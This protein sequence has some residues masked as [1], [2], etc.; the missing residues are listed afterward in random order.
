MDINRPAIVHDQEMTSSPT[1]NN[2]DDPKST[3]A[4]SEISEAMPGDEEESALAS[5]TKIQHMSEEQSLKPVPE[6]P[7]SSLT[8]MDND[9]NKMVMME[10]AGK[11]DVDNN[12]NDSN[13]G[14]VKPKKQDKKK[15]PEMNPRYKDVQETGQW[16]DLSSR[17]FYIAIAAFLLVIIVV[18][19]VVV[20]VVILPGNNDG[21]NVIIPAPT[22]APSMPATKIPPQ[23]ELALVLAAIE[24]SSFTAPLL[25]DGTLPNNPQF[26]QG[27]FDDVSATPQQKAMDWLLFQDEFKDAEQSVFRFALASIY[28]QMSGPNWVSS[29]GW[30]TS[31]HLCEWDHITCDNRKVMQELD[32]AEQ[33]MTGTLPMDIALLAGTGIRSIMMSRNNISGPIPGGVLASL[34]SLSILYLDNNALTG[35]IPEEL[36]V[37]ARLRK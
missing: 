36:I 34:S 4:E 11:D 13:D 12:D 20:F 3:M 14:I 35:T 23:E 1:I 8:P 2:I 7:S 10:A 32:L 29:D 28:F 24:Q 31:G 9:N 26:Y 25:E 21:N 37:D 22:N 27:L 17:E 6:E 18:V 5:Y 16:G 19:L 15:L 30:L 33:D